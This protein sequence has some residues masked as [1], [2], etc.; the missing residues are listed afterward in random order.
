MKELIHITDNFKSTFYKSFKNLKTKKEEL[1][2]KQEFTKWDFDPKENI[3]RNTISIDKNL[4]LEK[5]LYKEKGRRIS[6]AY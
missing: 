6:G 1:F 3:D 2:K 5:M 4:A